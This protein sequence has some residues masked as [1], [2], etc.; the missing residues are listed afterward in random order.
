M[1]V[2]EPAYVTKFMVKVREK[3]LGETLSVLRDSVAPEFRKSGFGEMLVVGRRRKLEKLDSEG[4]G[5]V[6]SPVLARLIGNAPSDNPKYAGDLHV[7][8][9][10]LVGGVSGY[11]HAMMYHHKKKRY[12]E[13]YEMLRREIYSEENHLRITG[14]QLD[15]YA[16]HESEADLRADTVGLD[17]R[18]LYPPHSARFLSRE[19]D[20]LLVLGLQGIHYTVTAGELPKGEKPGSKDLYAVQTLTPILFARHQAIVDYIR[21]L[22]D[23]S[24]SRSVLAGAV[25]LKSRGSGF[26]RGLGW[27]PRGLTQHQGDETRFED[28][29]VST[30]TGPRRYFRDSTVPHELVTLW[31]TWER[32]E[33][34]VGWLAKAAPEALGLAFPNGDD[35]ERIMNTFGGLVLRL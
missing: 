23:G 8:H 14:A 35:R 28:N 29:N 22:A 32:R 15:C 33:P 20:G 5:I 26:D 21:I 7:L 11:V 9:R 25:F 16:F 13:E 17:G 24:A 12:P 1:R 30:T 19:L 4:P 3:D 18:N 6:D 10:T 31:R 27:S 34:G 2:G